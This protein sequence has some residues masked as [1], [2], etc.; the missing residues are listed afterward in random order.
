M[1]NG[2]ARITII[3]TGLIG[4]SI[5]L[6]LK[7]AKVGYEI[8]GHDREHSEATLAKKKGAID[9]SEWNLPNAVE[10]A[11]LVILAVPVG[12]LETLF[13]N[14]APYLASGAVVTDTAT[15]SSRVEAAGVTARPV[16]SNA[17]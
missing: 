14:I 1:A 16:Y 10:G 9:K 17:V 5:G 4:T 15:G 3:G 6:A 12:A 11:S 8:V 13:Q 2:R 7:A